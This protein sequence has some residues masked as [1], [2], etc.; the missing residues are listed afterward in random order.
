VALLAPLALAPIAG[1]RA[2]QEGTAEEAPKPIQVSLEPVRTAFYPGQDLLVNL[3]FKGAGDNEVIV[4]PSAFAREAFTLQDAEGQPPP[5]SRPRDGEPGAAGPEPL[6]IKGF[7]TETRQVN[8]SA[9]YPKLTSKKGVWQVAWAHGERRAVPLKVPVVKAYR[10]EKDTMAE[11]V[12]E[13]GVMKWQLMP[14]AAPEHVKHFVDLVRTG[15]Y[16]GLTIFRYVPGLYAEG[17]D[18]AGDGTGA[19]KRVMPPELSRTL[20][21]TTGLV[22]ASRQETSMTSDTMFFITSSPSEFMQGKQTFYAKVVEGI[23]VIARLH[24][25]P[26]KGDTGLRDE[27][28]LVTPVKIL[29]VTIR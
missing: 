6:S 14:E 4:D 21:L 9:W 29:S 15:F 26:N 7:D 1:A 27:Y 25:L 28:M 23:E 10:A 20:K 22:G 16:D 5:G 19:W 12:T 8:L 3:V 2:A 24:T 17:G 11:V 13:L 18:A